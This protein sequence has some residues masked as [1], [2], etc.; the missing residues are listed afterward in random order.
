MALDE[1]IKETRWALQ[2]ARDRHHPKAVRD[3]RKSLERLE[4]SKR[5]GDKANLGVR[6][7]EPTL[8]N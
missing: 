1:K 2:K 3:L 5:N 8:Q 4:R 6:A 7:D